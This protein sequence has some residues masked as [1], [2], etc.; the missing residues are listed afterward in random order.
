ME[1]GVGILGYGFMGRSHTYSLVTIPLYYEPIPFRIKHISI[2]EPVEKSRKA[3]ENAGYYRR[4]V[5][6][7]H[8]LIDDPEIDVIVVSSPN[9]FHKEQLVA[10]IEAGKHVYCDKPVVAS[11]DD[12]RAV[13]DALALKE[14]KGKHQVAFQF[15]CFPA[16][17]RAKQLIDEGFFG[18]I[19]HYRASYLHSSG[20]DPKKP[21]HWKSDKKR[22]GGG[23][24]FDMG[25]HMLDLMSLYM[26]EI[27]AVQAVCRTF[28][29]ERPLAETGEIVPVE[30][31]DA[32]LT[33]LRHTSGA[34]GLL[35]VSK[36]AAGTYD[37]LRFEIH[38]EFGAM[39]FNLMEPNWLEVYDA[40][41]P[42]APL[43]GNRGFKKVECI[44]QYPKPASGFPNPKFTVGWL[45]AHV[46]SLYK[47]LDCIAQDQTPNPSLLDGIRIQHALDAVY[48][49]SD[50]GKWVTVDYQLP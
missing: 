49:A 6:D 8:D 25:V 48:K 23:A 24:F 16:T 2:C 12:A 37:D 7:F 32:A 17:L 10:A 31:E 15:R 50:A 41:D 40:R 9:K 13:T 29:K 11:L 39:R 21:M 46:H 20:I 27:E 36:V 44:Q 3:A 43:G 5:S 38:G 19:F 33:I 1:L 4:I 28:F 26:G 47:F 22:G 35:D 45:R 42:G 14:Y 34:V 18:R 30:T